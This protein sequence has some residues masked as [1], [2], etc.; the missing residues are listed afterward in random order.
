MVFLLCRC[1]FIGLLSDG[2]GAARDFRETEIVCTLQKALGSSVRNHWTF[3]A[4]QHKAAHLC[5][6][7]LI[8]LCINGKW[9]V[10]LNIT[11]EHAFKD[12][13]HNR[14]PLRHSLNLICT[15]LRTVW[16]VKTLL[17]I[18]LTFVIVPAFPESPFEAKDKGRQWSQEPHYLSLTPASG[19]SRMILQQN[20]PSKTHHTIFQSLWDLSLVQSLFEEWSQKVSFQQQ[21]HSL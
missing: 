8:F 3:L 16:G 9:T 4:L 12:C 15:C 11:I 18:G 19:V 1:T 17:H 21:P 14:W 6:Q 5:R 7:A 10:P 2:T 20:K 13:Q